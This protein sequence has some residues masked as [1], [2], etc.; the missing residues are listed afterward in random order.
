MKTPTAKGKKPSAAERTID[1]FSAP[2]AT[3]DQRPVEVVAE[4]EKAE[5]VPLEQD[6][7]RLRNTA[8]TYQQW[9]TKAFGEPDA[10]GNQYRVSYRSPHYYLEALVKQGNRP[11]YG[12]SGYMV[13]ERDLY[14]VTQV[15]VQAVREKQK[16]E[17]SNG[18]V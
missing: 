17:Q 8:F 5:R 7:D 13:H 14:S 9:T 12:Y 15:L 6:V 10:E 18:N 1:M 11:A 3:I 2:A 4:E 16:R